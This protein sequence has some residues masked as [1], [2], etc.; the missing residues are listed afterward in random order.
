M[1]VL[2][3]GAVLA[4]LC[5]AAAG[6]AAGQTATQT[7]TFE[8]AAINQIGVSGPPGALVINAATAGSAPNT[9]TENTTTWAVTTNQTNQKITASI[10][11]NMPA[12]VTL[13]VSLAA[14][15]GASSAGSQAL[16]T[17]AA[18]LVTGIT[19]LNA[20][21]LGITYTLTATSAAGQVSS[22]TRVVTFTIT[23]G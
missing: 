12:G 14:P 4:A 20:S 7:V 22:S 16:S 17:T 3:S 19:G 5:L 21:S 1:R 9:V 10:P 15:S 6:S 18:D 2:R 23:A 11:S 13:S 8:V